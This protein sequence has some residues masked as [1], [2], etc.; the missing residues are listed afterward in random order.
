M[1][2]PEAIRGVPMIKTWWMYLSL[3]KLSNMWSVRGLPKGLSQLKPIPNKFFIVPVAC[4]GE[5][6]AQATKK[7]EDTM[8]RSI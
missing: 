8:R 4:H 2:L 5:L 1:Y 6:H 3:L 7:C